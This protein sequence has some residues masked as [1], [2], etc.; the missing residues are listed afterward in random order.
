M[1]LSISEKLEFPHKP[2]NQEN[3]N[4]PKTVYAVITKFYPHNV[5]VTKSV[6]A[7]FQVS[8]MSH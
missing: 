4:Y 5:Y 2:L 8:V 6:C 7:K 3:R 1:K